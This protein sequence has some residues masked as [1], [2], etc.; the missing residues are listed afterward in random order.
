MQPIALHVTK[1]M[2]KG[3]TCEA[4]GWRCSG[5]ECRQNQAN[6]CFVGR[7][8]QWRYALL[9]AAE[10]IPILRRSSVLQ[11]TTGPTKRVNWFNLLKFW[12]FASNR[13]NNPLDQRNLA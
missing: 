12:H 5:V 7:S 6:L 10:L 9:E 4:F 1:P 11:R 8:K 3:R 2:A 13:L